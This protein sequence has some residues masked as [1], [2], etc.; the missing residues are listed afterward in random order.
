MIVLTKYFLLKNSQVVKIN[1][2][3]MRVIL[4]EYLQLLIDGRTVGGFVYKNQNE[5]F[6]FPLNGLKGRVVRIVRLGEYL[7]LCEV[8]VMGTYL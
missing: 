1:A 5:E 4:I 8:Q 7:T 6:K 2:K 3:R